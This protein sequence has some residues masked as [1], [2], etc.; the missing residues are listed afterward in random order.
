VGLGLWAFF[1]KR[2]KLYQLATGLE[3]RVLA[4]LGRKRGRFTSLPL[5][6]GWTKY[7]ELPAPQGRTFQSRWKLGERPQAG[8]AQ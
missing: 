8:G 4:W 3:M 1:A 7:R 6:G 2:P 5:A